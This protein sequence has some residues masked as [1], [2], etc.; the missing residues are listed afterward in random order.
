MKN[1]LNE[2]N[3]EDIK[4]IISKDGTKKISY[5]FKKTYFDCVCDSPEHTLRVVTYEDYDDNTITLYIDAQMTKGP[6]WKRLFKGIKY[7]FGYDSGEGH[8]FSWELNKNDTDNFIEILSKY[9]E[10]KMTK[11]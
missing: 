1:M 7:I 5:T 9:K 3:G 8:W 10:S 11:L 4:K 2:T 6:F